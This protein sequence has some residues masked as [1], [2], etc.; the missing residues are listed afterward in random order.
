MQSKTERKYY[1][2]PTNEMTDNAKSYGGFGTNGT[3]TL[4]EF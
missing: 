4:L 2:K 3:L 1:Y